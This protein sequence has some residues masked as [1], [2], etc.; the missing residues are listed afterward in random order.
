MAAPV[1][2]ALPTMP[3]AAPVVATAPV[4]SVIGTGHMVHVTWKFPS[5][6]F[7]PMRLDEFCR[8]VPA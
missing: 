6:A 1:V 7:V 3:I 5:D 2:A 8:A 4:A